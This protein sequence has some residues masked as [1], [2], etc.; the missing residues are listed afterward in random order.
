MEQEEER[1]R[2][3]LTERITQN[4]GAVLP[5][6]VL[7][8]LSKSLTKF[9]PKIES[10]IDALERWIRQLLTTASSTSIPVPHGTASLNT[11]CGF[12]DLCSASSKDEVRG[13]AFDPQTWT[14]AFRILLE[15]SA[16]K[17]AKPTRRLLT[18][19][20][21]LLSRQPLDR[22]KKMLT[23]SA[24]SSSVSAL[25]GSGDTI[26]IKM[27]VQ[28]LEHLLVKNVIAASLII[29]LASGELEQNS[30]GDRDACASIS[31]A[32]AQNFISQILEWLE[33]PDCVSA[34]SRFLPVFV[35]ALERKSF[36]ERNVSRD[37]EIKSALPIWIDPVKL[38]H[39]KYP[40][41]LESLEKHV[42]P[43]LLSLSERDSKAFL[44][45]LP[46]ENIRQGSFGSCSEADLQLCLLTARVRTSLRLGKSK[47]S[48]G[49]LIVCVPV[50]VI[51]EAF[52]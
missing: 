6:D 23:E 51:A 43:C 45:T 41:N 25:F 7:R 5:E 27:A 11:L 39:K 52:H 4:G 42:L 1:D 12:L 2:L 28:V 32:K 36:S 21:G 15:S 50:C 10:S 37:G 24:V 48:S 14:K 33:Y 17:K 8:D 40:L 20:T 22:V 35:T 9:V 16:N 46:L 31:R 19:L 49:L 44:D 18:T 26:S 29:D 47:S 38:Y 34:I 30:T 13:I 3:G